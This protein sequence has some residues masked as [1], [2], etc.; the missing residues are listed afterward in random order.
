M[1]I[2]LPVAWMTKISFTWAS[3]AENL[4]VGTVE[5]N[6]VASTTIRKQVPS[7]LQQKTITMT[8][9]V[10]RRKDLKKRNT[11]VEDVQDIA[12][13]VG[14]LDF[15]A[16]DSSFGL[17]ITLRNRVLFLKDITFY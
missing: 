12:P 3:D 6:I 8:F 16:Y 11:V 17:F 13:L 2:F 10:E 4:G 9:V 1:L 7:C 15:R 5:R 14:S